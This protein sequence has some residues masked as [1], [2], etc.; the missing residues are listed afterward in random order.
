M[1]EAKALHEF[2]SSF[3]W[4]AYDEQTVP[5]EDQNPE[6]PRITYEVT[7]DE[8]G[9]V[10]SLSASLWDRSYSWAA[11]SE[12]AEEI[13]SYIGRG[14]I[15]LRF[16]DGMMWVKRGSPFSQRMSDEDDTIRRIVLNIE[17]E[18]SAS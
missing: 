1:N 12:K 15:I 4:K 13:N 3:G 2:W 10:V 9:E 7:T 6:I 8:F 18:F 11:I 14:G 5:S 16:T 17:V